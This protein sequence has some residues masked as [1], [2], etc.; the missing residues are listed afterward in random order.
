MASDSPVRAPDDHTGNDHAGTDRQSR[1]EGAL[2][3]ATV[4]NLKS[5]RPV[6]L[7][8]SLVVCAI[9]SQ[10]TGR[11]TA[12]AWTAQMLVGFAPQL[13]VLWRFPRHTLAPDQTRRWT[14]ILAAVNLFFVANW[15]SLGWH[16]WVP[17][18]PS[19][20]TMIELFLAATM[21]AHASA[22]GPSR[23]MA[24]PALFLYLLIMALAPLQSLLTPG[25]PLTRP[26]LT[27]LA[28]PFYVGFIAFISNRSHARA[29]AAVL[30]CEERNALMAEL[31][32]AKLESDRGRERAEAAS[33]A[34]SQF[35]ANMSHELRTPLNAI[36]GFSEMI[37]S[38]MFQGHPDRH[39]EYAGLIHSS[40]QHL[41][42]LINDILDLAKIEAGRWKLAEADLDLHRMAEE[43]LQLVSWRAM[44]NNTALESAID[45]AIG[46]LH[47]D[48]RAVRQILTNLLSNAVKFTPAGGHV[49]IFARETKAGGLDFGVR[50]SGIGIGAEDLDRVFDSFGQ[51]K[52]DIAI[53]DK[54]TGLGLAIVKGLS[55]AHGGH[56]SLES[57]V[58]KG[59]CVTVHMPA[60]RLRP[61]NAVPVVA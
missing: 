18:R 48:E 7:A 9:F 28:A 6:V 58:G 17:G 37:A 49:T 44:N 24:R 19:N 16:F 55:E 8:F 54:G 26:L 59:T 23:A 43:T 12:V 31:V 60:H 27:A 53:A 11:M 4:D 51:G 10:W 20:H 32:A 13:F 50:D 47:A 14:A 52:H 33:R 3:C 46:L 22:I 5:N 56:V 40:G 1:I 39:F 57:E 34:K 35:L 41:L 29:R 45:P 61:R 30:L 15:A 2:L 38:R 21:T 42:A 36:L 25:E